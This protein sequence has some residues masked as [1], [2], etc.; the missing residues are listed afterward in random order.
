MCFFGGFD[1]VFCS[2]KALLH[3]FGDFEWFLALI[4]LFYMVFGGFEVYLALL[5]PLVCVDFCS[6]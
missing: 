1:V 5:V 3:G 4:S 6:F 2:Y